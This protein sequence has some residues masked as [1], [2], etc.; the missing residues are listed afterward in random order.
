MDAMRSLAGRAS[1]AILDPESGKQAPEKESVEQVEEDD[2]NVAEFPDASEKPQS[3]ADS[4]LELQ[5]KIFSWG[6]VP[7]PA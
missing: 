7:D 4:C 5:Q 3:H 1:E 2:D 6:I